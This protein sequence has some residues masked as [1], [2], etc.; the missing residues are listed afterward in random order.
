MLADGGV[1]TFDFTFSGKSKLRDSNSE[2]QYF[3]YLPSSH[4]LDLLVNAQL[5]SFES[6]LGMF[7]DLDTGFK[8]ETDVKGQSIFPKGFFNFKVSLKKLD[9]ENDLHDDKTK[10]TEE[11]THDEQFDYVLHTN[12][13]S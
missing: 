6:E 9:L 1:H 8:I 2:T 7:E 3:M 10:W 4:K 5:R 12:D 13:T 11:F